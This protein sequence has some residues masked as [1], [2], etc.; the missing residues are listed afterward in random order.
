MNYKKHYYEP[1]LT[2]MNQNINC[3]EPK[4]MKLNKITIVMH[5]MA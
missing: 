5:S 2:N 1:K 4:D 3:Y